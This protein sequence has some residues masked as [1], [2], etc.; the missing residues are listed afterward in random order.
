ML[1]QIKIA[2]IVATIALSNLGT[3]K[4]MTY[5]HKAEQLDVVGEV[6]DDHNDDIKEIAEHEKVMETVRI[7]YRDKVIQLPPIIVDAG[8]P[9][10]PSTKLRNEIATGLPDMY[11]ESTDALPE[12]TD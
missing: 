8:C 12:A 2:L 11:F 6:I 10:D 5:K 7:E 9:I 1:I 4:Y 3:Y